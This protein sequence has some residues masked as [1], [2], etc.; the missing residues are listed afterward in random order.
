MGVTFNNEDS[1]GEEHGEGNGNWGD[2]Q[3]STLYEPCRLCKHSVYL[4][5]SLDCSNP[6]PRPYEN[7]EAS[8]FRR[9]VAFALACRDL[10][11]AAFCFQHMMS[12]VIFQEGLVF[13]VGVWGF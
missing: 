12:K 4:C 6:T 7:S 11:I 2:L 3:I 13:G 1:H 5:P 9:A 8:P 10:G